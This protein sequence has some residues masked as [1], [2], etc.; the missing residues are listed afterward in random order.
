MLRMFQQNIE[1]T[2]F[3]F[4]KHCFGSLNR[5]KYEEKVLLWMRMAFFLRCNLNYVS[6]SIKNEGNHPKVHIN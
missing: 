1:T 2:L 6:F 5:N 4:Y 3:I